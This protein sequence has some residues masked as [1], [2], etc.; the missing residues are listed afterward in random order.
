VIRLWLSLL[1]AAL[2]SGIFIRGK[3]GLC[4]IKAES[5]DTTTPHRLKDLPKIK[6]KRKSTIK[7]AK[8]IFAMDAAPAATPPKPNI[9]AITATIKK[10]T[11]QRNINLNLMMIDYV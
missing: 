6:D 11:V 1:P 2:Y 5:F 8:S 7:M 4:K 9:A 3:N 10:V